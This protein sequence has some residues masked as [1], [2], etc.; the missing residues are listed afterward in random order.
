[1][2]SKLIGVIT[3]NNIKITGKSNHS[4]ARVIGSVEQR[5]SGVSVD[6]V[7]NALTNKDSEVSQIRKQ[8]RGERSQ[9]FRK[10]KVMISVNPD[11]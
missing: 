8:G 10:D 9:K 7:L 5:R 1:M 6:K 2:D 3:S 11:T 4:I